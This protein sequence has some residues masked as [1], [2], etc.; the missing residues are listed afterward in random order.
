MN[1]NTNTLYKDF[2][3]A[4][5]LGEDLRDLKQVPEEL[6]EDASIV[7]KDQG[8][9]HVSFTSKGDSMNRLAQFAA[10]DRNA[11][12]KKKKRNRAAK[13]SRRKNRR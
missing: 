4:R 13:Q 7:L 2:E 5:R 1:T 3:T 8:S 10:R 11:R 9:V 12:A 6:Q